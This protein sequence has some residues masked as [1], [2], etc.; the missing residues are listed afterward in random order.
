ML[1]IILIEL[2]SFFLVADACFIRKYSKKGMYAGALLISLFCN[3]VLQK[4][5]TFDNI[6]LKA[7]PV[8]IIFECI[9]L[10]FYQGNIWKEIFVVCCYYILLYC[11]DYLVLLGMLSIGKI[12]VENMAERPSLWW[13]G[14]VLAKSILFISC[15]IFKKKMQ[16]SSEN[17][18]QP[19][20]YWIQILIIPIGMILNLCL[21]IFYAIKENIVNFWIKADVIILVAGNILFLFL[22]QKLENERREKILNQTLSE[23]IKSGKKQLELLMENYR[24]QRSLTH[25]FQNHLLILE[26]MLQKNDCQKA[27]KYLKN[28]LQET[29]DT[30]MVVHTNYLI[31]DIILNKFYQKAKSQNIMME[32]EIEELRNISL[33][34]EDLVIIISNVLDNAIEAA[35]QT[36]TEK[37]II[38][39]AVKKQ[40]GLLVSVRNTT[41]H[42]DIKAEEKPKTTKTDTLDH[43]YGLDNIIQVIQKNKGKYA[44]QCENGWFTITII[45]PDNLL[46]T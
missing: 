40:S 9:L 19:F 6:Y 21:I 17:F 35:K 32:F 18:R 43:G 3:T 45:L 7:L 10:F 16:K 22:E 33:P 1:I 39:R 2:L 46:G 37:R 13:L 42:E 11:I 4:L 12:S 27:E 26:G 24:K 31:V 14:T 30:E 29:E 34:E 28:L 41:I 8:L 36:E 38:V 23:E 44:L 25:D 20:I 15:I 5:M